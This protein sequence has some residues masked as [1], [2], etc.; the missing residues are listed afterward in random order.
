[1]KTY[2]LLMILMVIITIIENHITKGALEGKVYSIFFMLF[3]GF[4]YLGECIKNKG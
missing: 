4:L 3:F 1:M 2:R